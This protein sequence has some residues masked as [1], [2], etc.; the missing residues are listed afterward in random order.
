MRAVKAERQHF[1]QEQAAQA[2]AHENLSEGHA[3]AAGAGG[4]EIVEDTH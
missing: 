3:A 1:N 2:G 4:G